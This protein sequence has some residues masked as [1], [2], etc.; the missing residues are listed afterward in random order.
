MEL[1]PVVLKSILFWPLLYFLYVFILPRIFK[2]HKSSAIRRLFVFIPIFIIFSYIPI[3]AKGTSQISYISIFDLATS[4]ETTVMLPFIYIL[5]AYPLS[6]L[7]LFFKKEYWLKFSCALWI[8][9]IPILF[10]GYILVQ[11]KYFP[12]TVVIPQAIY[13]LA[14]MFMPLFYLPCFSKKILTKID[15]PMNNIPY[16]KEFKKASSYLMKNKKD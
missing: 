7:L 6:F 14:T 9:S 16:A 12:A 1:S 3:I 10:I 5:L 13:L 2:A 15:K 11:N 4:M 8:A